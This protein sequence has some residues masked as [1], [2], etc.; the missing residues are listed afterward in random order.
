MT[1]ELFALY[2]NGCNMSKLHCNNQLV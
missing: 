2:V 1:V